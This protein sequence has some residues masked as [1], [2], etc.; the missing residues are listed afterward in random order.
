MAPEY[1][2]SLPRHESWVKVIYAFITDPSIGP[3]ARVVREA[4]AGVVKGTEGWS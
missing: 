1:Y 3:Y 4:R 2:D